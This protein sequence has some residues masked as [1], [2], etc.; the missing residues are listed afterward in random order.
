MASPQAER[1][2]DTRRYP[3][4]KADARK[5]VACWRQMLEISGILPLAAFSRGGF[6]GSL[7]AEN[8][9]AYSRPLAAEARSRAG[10][11]G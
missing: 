1:G 9:L 8:G 2:R 11:K 7:L 10:R 5:I 4:L 6:A 3:G